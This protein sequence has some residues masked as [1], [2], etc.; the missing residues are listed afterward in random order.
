MKVKMWFSVYLA[1][2]LVAT[3]YN[4]LE[5]PDRFK[6]HIGY[7]KSAN[8]TQPT[9]NHFN[10]PGHTLSNMKVTVHEK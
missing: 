9:G 6:E 7:V 3:I 2:N 5:K 10:L 1:T 4:I 8:L